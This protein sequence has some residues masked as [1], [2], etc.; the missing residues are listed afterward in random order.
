MGSMSIWHWILVALIIM[1]LF[2]RG[3]ISEMMGDLA[4]GINAFKK[5]LNEDDT[6]PAPPPAQLTQAPPEPG[7]TPN[8]QS[9]P[10]RH[11]QQ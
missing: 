8:V 5:G 10:A 7:P 2:G 9:D 4:K 3:R 11:S 6:K 1:L